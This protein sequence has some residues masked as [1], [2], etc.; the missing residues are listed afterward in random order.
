MNLFVVGVNHKI[1]SVQLREQLAVNSSELVSRAS[2]V[3]WREDLD[4][5]V[6]LSTCNRVEIYATSSRQSAPTSALLA[7]LCPEACDFGQHAYVHEDREAA[8]H[9]F[10]DD[11]N[12][13]VCEN[14]SNRQQELALCDRII[15]TGV[16]SLMT[17]LRSRRERTCGAAPHPL[18]SRP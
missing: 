14:M 12:A 17:K 18:P 7:S 15:E 11:L 10:R 8:R 13:I 1:G 4:E 9:L 6:L 2:H 5:I 3:K 16:A